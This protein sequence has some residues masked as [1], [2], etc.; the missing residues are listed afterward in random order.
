MT[1]QWNYDKIHWETL[2]CVFLAAGCSI[3]RVPWE[4]KK[5]RLCYTKKY[6]EEFMT[7]ILLFWL[8]VLIPISFLSFLIYSDFRKGIKLLRKIVRGLWETKKKKIELQKKGNRRIC[9]RDITFLAA[10]PPPYIIFCCFFC[11]L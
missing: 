8:H 9:V 7:G 5:K 6:I 1:K 4:T 11:L 10:L 2:E 3:I